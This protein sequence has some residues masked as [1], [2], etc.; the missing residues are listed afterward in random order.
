MRF[1]GVLI[2]VLISCSHLFASTLYVD[3]NSPSSTAPFDRWSTAATNIQQAVDLSVTGDTIVVADGHY[4][5]DAEISITNSVTL[6]SLNGPEATIIDGRGSVRCFNLNLSGSTLSGLTITNGYTKDSGGGVW[7]LG[8]LS[9]VTNCLIVGNVTLGRGGGMYHGTAYDCVISGNSADNSGGIY[10]G[11]ANHCIISNNTARVAGGMEGC[12]VQACI[13]RDNSAE[14]GGGMYKGTARN[15]VFSGNKARYE[16]GGIYQGTAYNCTISGNIAERGGGMFEGYAYN[17]I[18]WYN[19]ASQGNDLGAHDGAVET[20]F[21]CSPDVMHGRNGNITNAPQLISVSHVTL[22][23]PCIGAGSVFCIQGVDIDG[24]AW[25]S[26]P[27]MGCDESMESDEVP[28]V[29]IHGSDLRFAE[30]YQARFSAE[31]SGSSERYIWDFGDGSLVTNTAYLKH[32]WTAAGLYDVVLTTYNES[33]PDGISATQTIDVVGLDST[34]VYVSVDDGDDQN[35]GLSLGSAKKTIQAGV[36]VQEVVGGL[37]LVDDGIYAVSN[38]IVVANP[39]W[40]RSR[41][42]A[43]TTSVDGQNLTRSFELGDTACVISGFSIINGYASRER[44]GLRADGA[45]IYCVSPLPSMTACVFSNN[46]AEGDGGGMS[47]GYAEDCVFTENKA[48]LGGGISCGR[49]TNCSFS[50]NAAEVIG[51]GMI[52]GTAMSCEFTHNFAEVNGGGVASTTANNCL[53][54]GNVAL[55]YGGGLSDSEAKDCTI[56]TNAAGYGGGL[57][58]SDALRCTIVG[59]TA[60]GNGGGGYGGEAIDCLISKN[61]AFYGG[62]L[63]GGNADRCVIRDNKAIRGGGV[64]SAALDTMSPGSRI[65]NSA[66]FGNAADIGGGLFGGTANNSTITENSARRAGGGVFGG[67]VNNSI[68][69]GNKAET[70]PDLC[71][72]EYVS[73]TCSPDVIHGTNGNITNAPTL[74][75]AA[76]LAVNSAGVGAGSPAYLSGTDIDGEAWQNPPSMGCDEVLNGDDLLIVRILCSRTCTIAGG[77]PIQFESEISGPVSEYVWDFGDGVT[78]K[79]VLYLEHVWD[80]PGIYDVALTAYSDAYPNGV[81]AVQTI[82]VFSQ[83]STTIYVAEEG[84]DEQD[85]TSW[86]KAKATIQAGVDAQG[87]LGGC[88]LV[89][90]GT[91]TV[92][93]EIVLPQHPILVKGISAPDE[94]IV[95]GPCS[96]T[97]RCFNLGNTASVIANFTITRGNSLYSGGGIY[98]SG[99]L[100]VVT[101]C[102]IS[103]NRANGHGGG[104]YQGTLYN[105]IIKENEAG[106]HGGGTFA[107]AVENCMIFRNNA[108]YGGG[109]CYGTASDCSIGENNACYGGGLAEVVVDRCTIS[110]N[111][112][113]KDGGGLYHCRANN[114]I[115]TYNSAGFGGGLFYGTANNDT[116]VNNSAN[117]GGGMFGGWINNSIAYHNHNLEGESDNLYTAKVSYTCAPD[118][119]PNMD[120]NIT[121]APVFSDMTS[122]NYQLLNSSPCINAGDNFTVVGEFDFCGAP[123]I[124]GVF[125]DMG[126]YEYTGTFGEDMDH[127]EMPDEWEAEHF[128]ANPMPDDNPDQDG[129]SNLDEYIAGTDP[130]DAVSSFAITNCFSGDGFTVEWGPSVAGRLYRVV[131]SSGLTNSVPIVLQDNIEYPQSSYTDT[132]YDDQTSGFYRVEV[133]LPD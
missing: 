94:T 98:C 45:G 43:V 75:S 101:N 3:L 21:V 106:S 50:D 61:L 97:N 121:N 88:V 130:T 108:Y 8:H 86:A 91:Y 39:V 40:I 25:R 113:S 128:F 22:N 118:V 27:S 105:C 103:E 72:S 104:V 66:V 65:R 4:Q 12:S 124:S 15:C 122:G 32:A 83:E 33:Y 102:V 54:D 89:S 85:G 68:V 90:N 6:Q 125:V 52:N 69:Y 123:R 117:C 11:A 127:D 56:T 10:Y 116:I 100:P 7:S 77:F 16:G 62:G 119:L 80:S 49:A 46:W 31:I 44:Y 63:Y 129:L 13:I 28:A 58:L 53:F 51:G 34:T 84:D 120:G 20:A 48:Y 5:L 19:I 24:E 60:D 1:F 14:R 17:C 79:N 110:G 78:A 73:F 29:Q 36:D 41:N 55:Y 111:A 35:N 74:I 133:R 92:T 18:V 82:E 112:A 23:S 115:I 132:E 107:S 57:S 96:G 87:F 81:S 109:L 76:H 64:Y 2:A 71:D 67:V 47:G 93:N 37:I 70:D 126:A 99:S 26:F 42:G 114:C 9:V 30:H 95:K 131:W 38:A 59:N